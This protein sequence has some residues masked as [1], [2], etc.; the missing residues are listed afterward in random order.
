MKRVVFLLII[1]ATSLTACS[2][3]YEC[4]RTTSN[5]SSKQGACFDTVSDAKEFKNN[6]QKNGYD[7]RAVP[8][9]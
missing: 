1:G 4:T 7:C 2:K 5:S 8:E 6:M 3:C 9:P